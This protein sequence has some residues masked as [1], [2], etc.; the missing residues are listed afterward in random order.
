MKFRISLGSKIKSKILKIPEMLYTSK[1][2]W[3]HVESIFSTKKYDLGHKTAF[4]RGG[5]F[6]EPP[7]VIT[8]PAEPMLNRVKDKVN[9]PIVIR[10][11]NCNFFFLN[12]N[13]TCSQLSFEVHNVSVAQNLKI[14]NFLGPKIGEKFKISDFELY[15]C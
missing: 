9:C 3:Y 15:A 12:L 4:Y 11:K 14:L 6:L 10:F 2:S 13:S 5:G 7:R 1:E 8:Y